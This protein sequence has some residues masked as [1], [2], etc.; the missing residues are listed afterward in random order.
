MKQLLVLLFAFSAALSPAV[1]RSKCAEPFT[2]AATAIAKASEL[3]YLT[4]VNSMDDY[5]KVAKLVETDSVQEVVKVIYKRTNPKKPEF[6][7][8]NSRDYD[9][10]EGFAEDYLGHESGEAAFRHKNYT[11]TGDGRDYNLGSLVYSRGTAK[12]GKDQ[13]LLQLWTGDTLEG[14]YLEEFYKSVRDHLKMDVPLVFNPLGVEQEKVAKRAFSVPHVTTQELYKDRVYL[15]LNKGKAYG[16]VKMVD[17]NDPDPLLEIT[18]IAVFDQVPNDIGL[19]GGVVTAE[20][21][22]PLSHVNVKS[23]NR[24]TVNMA[25]RNAREAL[26]PYVGKPIELTAHGDKY[27]IRE[28]P[29]HEAQKL[30]TE[31][32]KT[33]RPKAGERPQSKVDPKYLGKLMDLSRYYRALPTKEQHQDLIR[34]VGAKAANLAL[35]HYILKSNPDIVGITSPL[36]MGQ[37]FGFYGDF[38]ESSLDKEIKKILDRENLLAPDTTHLLSKVRPALEE[39]RSLILGAKVPDKIIAEFKKNILSDSSSPIFHKKQPI[40]LLRSS[41]NSEDMVGFSGAGL[42]NS[43]LVKIYEP[44]AQGKLKLRP[45]AEIEK[46]LRKAIPYVY[47]SVWNERAFLEREWYSVNGT[48]HLDVKAGIAVHGGFNGTVGEG[49]VGETAN[50]VAITA[51]INSP[52]DKTKIYIN[53]QHYGLSV[54]NPPSKE[55]LLKH[56]EKE[57]ENYL[58]EELFVTNFLASYEDEA[59]P[60]SWKQWPFERRKHSSVKGGAAV[61]TDSEVRRLAYALNKLSNQMATV[62]EQDPD[63]FIIDVEWNVFGK[64]RI[65]SINQ[66]RPFTPP[67]H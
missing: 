41:T 56:G 2:T 6:Y 30:I 37:H 63:T 34:M 58:T 35:I 40:L 51:D 33:R 27:T 47:S 13:V 44:D 25:L 57:R 55:E 49:K 22:T 62:Y 50:G 17:P 39:I 66:A 1:D 32:W 12:G 38:M 18:D 20:F 65:I 43:T 3:S 5:L 52:S 42:Y 10:H 64:N 26:A 45:W 24:G 19:V 54:T 29:E 31:F 8:I 67:G 53:G 21:Q 61:L 16:Y 28:L 23:M 60:E 11:G 4:E 59:R 36:P 15:P 7:F 48:Q 46:D 14:K 9:Y